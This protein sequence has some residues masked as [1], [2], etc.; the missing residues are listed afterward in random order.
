[1]KSLYEAAFQVSAESQ[2]VL[3]G[4]AVHNAVNRIYRAVGGAVPLGEAVR[5]DVNK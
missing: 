3:S 5:D 2:A 1:M 4:G